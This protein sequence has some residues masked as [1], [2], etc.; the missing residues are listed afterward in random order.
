MRKTDITTST[1]S[2]PK[3]ITHKEQYHCWIDTNIM[4][5]PVNREEMM[6]TKSRGTFFWEDGVDVF[7]LSPSAKVQLKPPDV[8]YKINKK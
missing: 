3:D 1:K 8:I 2:D 5:K 6:H 4:E 7:F